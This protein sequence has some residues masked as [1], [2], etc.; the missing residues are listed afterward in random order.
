[1]G[2]VDIAEGWTSLLGLIPLLLAAGFVSG[3]LAGLFGIGGGAVIIIALYEA[4][5]LAGV[6]E[7]V[8]MHLTTG[9]A[10]AIIAP[11]TLRSFQ[12]HR[13]RGAVDMDLVRR[14]APLVLVG[15][16]A[17]IIVAGHSGAGLLKGVWAVMG[18]AL[19]L[20]MFFARN[21]WRLGP[22]IPSS[23]LVEVYGIF[24]GF[25]STLMSIGGGAFITMLMSLYGRGVHQA[26]GTSSAF[27]PVIAVPGLI[28]FMWAGFGAPGLPPG[29]VG[30]VSLAGAALAIPTGLLAAPIGARLAHRFS[31]RQLEIAFGTFMSIVALRFLASLV[32]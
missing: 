25:I 20:R 26:V 17:G 4:F 1:M 12:V 19:A 31:K 28:G 22:D 10:L 8:R 6:E 21:S 18:T 16:A 13:G 3:F 29:S 23:R 11:T 14:L 7:S 2:G 5:R 24:V 15:V 27:G 32:T 9:T 30:Y